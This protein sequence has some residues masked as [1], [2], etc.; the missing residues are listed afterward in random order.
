[1]RD[2]FLVYQIVLEID[3]PYLINVSVAESGWLPE[4]P[5]YAPYENSYE[6]GVFLPPDPTGKGK[7]PAV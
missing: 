2:Q 1:M 4:I 6:R 7:A 3:K 5:G